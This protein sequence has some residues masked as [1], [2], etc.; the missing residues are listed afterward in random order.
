MHGIVNYMIPFGKQHF[1]DE[2]VEVDDKYK[3]PLSY[4]PPTGFGNAIDTWGR[5]WV[6][7][8]AASTFTVGT[9]RSPYQTVDRAA[10]EVGLSFAD[11]VRVAT[12]KERDEYR[13]E[14]E[15][16]ALLFDGYTAV[17]VQERCSA[18]RWL[19]PS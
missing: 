19:F 13:R 18:T 11:Q 15:F 2:K 17:P 12:P 8:A 1:P 4:V 7:T 3:Y 10:R 14:Q 6:D 16:L 5:R 9:D